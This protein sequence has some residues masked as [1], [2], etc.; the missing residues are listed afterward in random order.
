MEKFCYVVIL[1]AKGCLFHSLLTTGTVRMLGIMS[2]ITWNNKH[3]LSEGKLSFD[4]IFMIRD[5]SKSVPLIVSKY[6]TFLKSDKSHFCL[7]FVLMDII[8][9]IPKKWR[10]IIK[11]SS[12]EDGVTSASF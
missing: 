9:E 12:R 5:F 2:H 4:L 3:I 7:P 1:I 8:D 6:G 11:E 10:P